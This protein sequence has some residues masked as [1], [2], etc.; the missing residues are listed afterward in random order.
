M[1]MTLTA[2]ISLVL[3][4][5]AMAAL[6]VRTVPTPATV[7]HTPDA[8]G[9]R[10]LSTVRESYLRGEIDRDEYEWRVLELLTS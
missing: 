3:I 7:G 6:I 4:A 8:G 1:V 10:S 9:T 2:I 5:A